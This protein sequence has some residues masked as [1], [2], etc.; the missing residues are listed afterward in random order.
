MV[1]EK[2]VIEHQAF[3]SLSRDPCG[4]LEPQR[5]QIPLERANR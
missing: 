4:R 5:M 3:Y 1:S 2:V